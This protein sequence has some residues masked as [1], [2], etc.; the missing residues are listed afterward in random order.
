[1]R[2]SYLI[3]LLSLAIFSLGCASHGNPVAPSTDLSALSQPG[4]HAAD[5]GG[6]NRSFLGLWTI[7][8]PADR[9]NPVVIPDRAASMHLNALG[10]LDQGPCDNCLKFYDRQLISPNEM[11][12]LLQLMHP[13]P[14]SPR[15]MVFD[16]RGILISG[17]DY[18]FPES[19]RQIARGDTHLRLLNYDGYTSLF[20]PTEFPEGAPN[21]Q[22][23]TYIAGKYAPGGDLSATL[24]PFVA[25]MHDS[26]RRI[27][28]DPYYNGNRRWVHLAMPDGPVE[29]G[30]AIDACWTYVSEKPDELDDFPLS[31][32]CLEAYEIAPRTSEIIPPDNSGTLWVE[33]LDHQGLDTIDQV[34]VEAPDLFDGFVTLDYNSTLG[35]DRH[36]FTGTITNEHGAENGTYPALVKVTDT[37]EDPN[38]GPICAWDIAEVRVGPRNG[39]VR[40]WDSDDGYVD[41]GAVE[42][43]D[44][45]N[46]YVTGD[47]WQSVDF[48]PGPGI[49]ERY[50]G[51]NGACYV[52]KYDSAGNY[53]WVATWGNGNNYIE[54]NSIAI[55]ST[56]AVYIAGTF[57]GNV[58]FGP[59]TLLSSVNASYDAFVIKFDDSGNFQWAHSW[60]GNRVDQGYDIAVDENDGV[61]V[62][63]PFR[64]TVDFDPGP[65]VDEITCAGWWDCYLIRFGSDGTYQYV[66]TWGGIEED[67]VWEIAT[68]HNGGVYA[69]GVFRDTVDF[70]PGPS[71]DMHSTT[72]GRNDGDAF[73]SRFDLDGNF[74]W[75]VTWGDDGLQSIR[76]IAADSTGC[77]VADACSDPMDLDPGPGFNDGG[78]VDGGIYL[79]HFTTDGLLDWVD[80]WPTHYPGSFVVA[81]NQE[82]LYFII[83]FNWFDTV[84]LDP[85][86]GVMEH[87]TVDSAL[88]K[89]DSDG[90]FQWA[91]P[92]RYVGY[93]YR[94]TLA[95][96]S[97]GDA[98]KIGG[99]AGRVDFDPGPGTE[100]RSTN[101]YG[102][103]LLR[104]P[105]DGNW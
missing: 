38:L 71:S 74:K 28:Y 80:T 101:G 35:E 65:A 9:S 104:F 86:P 97:S 105:P 17:A 54:A 3:L 90:V 50:C 36:L 96:A 12:V 81:A 59:G 53:K 60:G 13:F 8:I 26:P 58:E 100:W 44:S 55:D 42:A 47:F 14:D 64:D 56:G 30:Y 57:A 49:D 32:N 10:F 41:S 99:F 70:D 27:F 73:I 48:D 24:N 15:L 6:P 39:W 34:T 69:T 18:T 75:A 84:D 51:D 52:V 68:D 79:S 2:G 91:Q 63:G 72:G 31:A 93:F 89:L 92:L 83:S 21:P 87:S 20:N 78:L 11:M 25:Y 16:V 23:L 61:Y 82:D 67:R 102:A 37:E 29:F 66:R 88:I 7:S 95:T 19:E 77:Y 40:T 45:G 46:V 85:G 76:T 33:V 103:Y 98:F 5:T 43:D 94:N 4:S 62:G 1:M 22:I